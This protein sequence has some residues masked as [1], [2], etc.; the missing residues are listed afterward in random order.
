MRTRIWNILLFL[1]VT[2]LISCHVYKNASS[3]VT[4]DSKAEEVP[5][6]LFL[7]YQVS[8]DTLNETL[9]VQLINMIIVNGK[10]KERPA[11]R[12]QPG[13][14]DLE[15]QVLDNQQQIITHQYIAYPLDRSVEYAND[16]GQ[17][18]RRMVH[19]DSAQ[20]SVRLQLEP[21]ASSIVIK[22]FIDDNEGTLLLQTPIQ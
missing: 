8:R 11:G 21:G 10:I 17:L 20:F 5:R 14:G 2:S 13:Q 16:N 12:F 7:D 9:N 6:I 15:L 18:E 19:L 1:L 4:G 3:S 22:R